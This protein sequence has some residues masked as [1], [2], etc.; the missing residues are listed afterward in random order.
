MFVVR[1]ISNGAGPM[2]VAG[3]VKAARAQVQGRTIWL[4]ASTYPCWRASLTD[5][6]VVQERMG[7][8]ACI[9][10]VPILIH[11]VGHALGLAGHGD[12]DGHRS[13]MDS[14]IS[15]AVTHPTGDDALDL[16]AV[17][18]SSVAGAPAGRL[19]ADAA[20]VELRL[21]R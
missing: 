1:W 14:Q 4:N 17:L 21:P 11:E 15:N 2:T 3:H 7:D 16:A 18:A 9:N 20:G 6:L 13:I 8:Q 12:L 10:L 5:G 19:D